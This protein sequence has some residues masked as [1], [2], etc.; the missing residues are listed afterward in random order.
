MPPIIHRSIF[1]GGNKILSI[2]VPTYNRP[3]ALRRLLTS[4]VDQ[5]T[6]EV[7]LIIGD[8]GD[9]EETRK[10]LGEFPDFEIIH[11]KNDDGP[12]FDKNLLAVTNKARGEYIWWFGDDDEFL[13]GAISTVL[14]LIRTHPDILY[15]W[16]DFYFS[17]TKKFTVDLPGSRLFTNR[18]EFLENIAV[19]IGYISASILKRKIIL[20]GVEKSKKYIGSAFVHVPLV[21]HALSQK[22]VYYYL[23]GPVIVNHPADPATAKPSNV[24][25]ADTSLSHISLFE[26]FGINF[27]NILRT[28][29]GSFSNKSIRRVIKKSFG[30][31]WRGVLVGSTAGWDTPEGKRWKMFVNFW[32]YPECYLALILFSLPPKVNAFL[33][34][35]Y[36]DI[37]RKK[38]F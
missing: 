14:G 3:V 36:K 21:L 15:I 26:V 10:V 32:M 37:R 16:A 35:K 2:C 11:F 23:Q 38:L 19:G 12:G 13:P 6:D 31:T 7:E 1:M 8:D 22:G 18:N 4:L 34:D 17:G 9:I 5:I 20:E 25:N 24:E 33:Y 28:F 29:R 27:A 30:S